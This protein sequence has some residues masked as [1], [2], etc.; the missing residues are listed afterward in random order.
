MGPYPMDAP[1][2][3]PLPPTRRR[4][5]ARAVRASGAVA[6]VPDNDDRVPSGVRHLTCPRS[7]STRQPLAHG[8][9]RANQRLSAY[10]SDHRRTRG[11]SR[12]FQKC[13]PAL[14]RP[15]RAPAWFPQAIMR[16]AAARR[17]KRSR[18]RTA[19]RRGRQHRSGRAAAVG[20]GAGAAVRRAGATARPCTPPTC[21][22]DLLVADCRADATAC[23]N[24]WLHRR[25]VGAGD[26]QVLP[27]ERC[28]GVQRTRKEDCYL[29]RDPAA[30]PRSRA[31]LHSL[32]RGRRR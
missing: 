23:R 29:R 2:G 4:A 25:G 11:V 12:R 27:L 9:A 22:P 5:P 3:R 14:Q 1:A 30:R 32:R 7:R 15:H 31:S 13:A 10:T 28:S 19:L 6:R 21:V 26:R 8:A 20:T 24:A 18:R 17:P 16:L